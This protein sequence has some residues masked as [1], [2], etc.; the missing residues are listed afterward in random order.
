MAIWWC[1]DTLLRFAETRDLI[2]H[3]P[4]RRLRCF[5]P[6]D[7]GESTADSC[8]Q[9]ELLDVMLP[10]KALRRTKHVRSV[11][12]TRT[13]GPLYPKLNSNAGSL[14]FAV[15]RTGDE[16]RRFPLRML[17]VHDPGLGGRAWPCVRV[18]HNYPGIRR[19]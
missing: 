19:Q 11:V 3:E 17:F 12:G 1:R 8:S 18:L 7:G 14:R 6:P 13:T 2:P 4:E 9:K 16:T 10:I 5:L 15:S